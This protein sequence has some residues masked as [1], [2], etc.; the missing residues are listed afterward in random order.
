MAFSL[1][2]SMVTQT[3]TDT[4]LA[5]L[6]GVAGV[7][8]TVRGGKTLYNMGTLRL[9]VAGTLSFNANTEAIN[10]AANAA[11]PEL[12]INAG[13]SLTIS[14]ERTTGTATFNTQDLGLIFARTGTTSFLPGESWVANSGTFTLNGAGVDANSVI[15]MSG[16]F[17]ANDAL[18]R[19][20]TLRANFRYQSPA[21]QI[22]GLRAENL[23]TTLINTAPNQLNGLS[24]FNGAFTFVT[25]PGN[26]A[27][28]PRV[29]SELGV[30][31]I[32]STFTNFGGAENFVE[33]N[34]FADWSGVEL[35]MNV[36]TN[37]SFR[38]TKDLQVSYKTLVGND[39]EDAVIFIPDNNN[40]NRP[41]FYPNDEPVIESTN[42]QGQATAKR[43]ALI[44]NITTNTGP[45]ATP[46]TPS[47]DF[48]NPA[49][50]DSGDDVMFV[51]AYGFV[52]LR[53]PVNL[54]GN[55]ILN[56]PVTGTEDV[57]VT[58]S[59]LDARAKLSSSFV[60]DPV[61]KTVTVTQNSNYDDVYDAL[62]AYKA[63]A[64]EVNLSQPSIGLGLIFE[65]NG[66]VLEAQNG[67]TVIVNDG[68]TLESGQKF[69]TIFATDI[70]IN[71]S[72]KITG[73]YQTNAGTSTIFTFGRTEA[74]I[75]AGCSLAIWDENGNTL[76]F[77]EDVAEGIYSFYIAPMAVEEPYFFAVERYG[78]RRFSGSFP[79]N[80]G[81]E[82]TAAVSF[83]EDI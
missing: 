5:A 25:L 67:Y 58:L 55:G 46:T 63:T 36:D 9:T 76:F 43:L 62:K 35:G 56:I 57:N 52:G 72:G 70:T 60:I 48:R 19:N 82:L 29:F 22:N 23:N 27:P 17:I 38:F 79:S 37:F 51:F 42:A 18:L 54:K 59:E 26:T 49:N 80:A 68:V 21:H 32:A 39:I 2:G 77:E 8:T 24:T 78:F 33:M 11:A 71:G 6:A 1:S 75:P 69:T 47:L 10:W 15:A 66:N 3:G 81:E 73:L 4:S 31:G 12:T 44:A 16:T 50:N 7:T 61:N 34:N 20:R 74:P 83:V 64:D 30:T 41:A 45:D 14:G 65:P 53:V 40:N 28:N 13:N